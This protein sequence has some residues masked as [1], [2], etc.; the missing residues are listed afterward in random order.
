MNRERLSDLLE[1][2]VEVAHRA[3]ELT[4]QYFQTELQVDVKAD[5]SPVT[6]ADRKAEMLCRQMIENRFPEDGILGEEFGESRAGS[7][8]RWVLDPIDGTK[9]FVRGAPLYGVLIALEEG[10]QDL[11]GV[12]HMPALR[13]TIFAARGE[14]C[15]WNDR[16]AHVSGVERL[17]RALLLTTDA[18]RLSTAHHTPAWNRLRQQANMVRTWGDCYGHALVA[19]GRAEGMFDPVLA[20][21]DA[22]ALRPVVEEAGGVFTD[23]HG[24]ATHRGGHG[25]STN[26]LLATEIR[27]IMNSEKER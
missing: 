10:D 15:W 16:R 27:R 4:L 20:A 22:A 17:D 5:A 19:T 9:N 3:G 6:I 14:G 24:N 21:W 7:A 8:R 13:E 25:V 12:I 2:A 18:E 26:A 23:W 11:L 1:F